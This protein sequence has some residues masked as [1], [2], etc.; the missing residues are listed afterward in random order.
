MKRI[1]ALGLC[2]VMLL[3]CAAALAETE[4]MGVLRVNK[5]F[6]I[7]YSPL[8]DGYEIH[9]Y[10]QNDMSILANIKSSQANL[11]GMG[12]AIAFND[13]WADVERLNDISEEDM[14]AI[15]DDFSFEFDDPEFETKE[16]AY[17]TLLLIVKVPGGQEAYVYTI[18]KGHEIEIQ[19]IPGAEQE[20][21]TDADIERVVAFLSDMQFVPIE[22]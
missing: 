18:Y 7:Q 12:L 21:L 1:I 14:Q 3:T 5:A 2:L 13:E 10:T 6:D 15:K 4:S 20:A 9:I 17:G 11:P 19:I 16:T 8:P 22:Q